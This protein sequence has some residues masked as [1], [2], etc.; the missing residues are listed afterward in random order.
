MQKKKKKKKEFSQIMATLFLP[1]TSKDNF[2]N[3]Q[4]KLL[5][6]IF[7][8]REDLQEFQE[9]PMIELNKMNRW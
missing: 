3:I 4:N 2:I 7:L 6:I 8:Y 1:A 5:W 9:I